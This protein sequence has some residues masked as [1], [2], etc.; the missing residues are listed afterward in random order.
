MSE[1]TIDALRSL[2]ENALQEVDDS[3]AEFQLRTA[4]Q[5][6]IALEEQHEGAREILE[7]AEI[8]G[9][10]RENLRELGYLD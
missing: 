3:E 2:L 4:L 5:L 7:E 8:D 10:V 9:E 1:T 6:L